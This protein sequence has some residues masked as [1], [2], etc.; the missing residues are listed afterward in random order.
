MSRHQNREHRHNF[1]HARVSLVWFAVAVVLGA[2]CSATTQRPTDSSPKPNRLAK[3]APIGGAS[4]TAL[5]QSA[6]IGSQKL[7]DNALPPDDELTVSVDKAA[8]PPA[9]SET[10]PEIPTEITVTEPYLGRI[11]ELSA[12]LPPYFVSTPK[13]RREHATSLQLVQAVRNALQQKRWSTEIRTG[14]PVE[15]DGRAF[16]EGRAVVRDATGKVRAYSESVG[17]D[18][19]AGVWKLYYDEASHLRTIVFQ[20]ASYTGRTAATVIDFDRVGNLVRCSSPPEEEPPWPCAPEKASAGRID[21]SVDS[22]LQPEIRERAQ[23]RE[24]TASPIHWALSLNP[25]TE[26]SKC[27]TPYTPNP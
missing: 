10:P 15:F 1:A 14:C 8:R 16:V 20:W 23:A 21:P 3:V 12:P 19:S 25:T 26:H 2:A 22:V 4:G 13:L 6:T 5:L 18:D 27:K 17:G 9:G 24:N 7:S 11:L